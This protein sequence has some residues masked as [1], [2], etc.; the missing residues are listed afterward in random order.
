METVSDLL[1]ITIP[2]AL[3]VYLSYLLVRSF[4]KS[5]REEILLNIRQKNQET[6]IPI[7]LQAYERIILLLERISLPHL[8]NRL[9]DSKYTAEEFQQILIM[10][11]RNEFNHNLSQQLYMSESAWTYVSTAVEHT[12]SQVNTA[13]NAVDGSGNA[14][15]LAKKLLELDTEEANPTQQA[16]AYLKKE[17]QEIF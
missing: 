10:E 15:S 16:I 2:A 7:R 14:M 6:V 11:I 1:K 12:I 3:V 8:L 5:Q 4:L 13:S 9:G 17:I